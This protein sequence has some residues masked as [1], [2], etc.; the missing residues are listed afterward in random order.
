MQFMIWVLNPPPNR[1]FR[2]RLRKYTCQIACTI[3][4]IRRT[5]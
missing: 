3:L 4:Y 5:V 2:V 1:P